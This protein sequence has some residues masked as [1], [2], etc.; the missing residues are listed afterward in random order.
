MT[1]YTENWKNAVAAGSVHYEGEPCPVCGGTKRYTKKR[2]CVAC[3]RVQNS[4]NAKNP[5]QF[6]PPKNPER[7][8]A[9]LSGAKT[10]EGRPCAICGGTT[11]N[12][13]TK[14]CINV[15]Q[16]RVDKAPLKI[17]KY[18]NWRGGNGLETLDEL[19][20]ADFPTLKA[21]RKELSRLRGEYES[22]GM[23][24]CYWSQ[25]PCQGWKK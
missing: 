22:S 24:G 1:Q 16:H 21:Y 15:Y 3:T 23:S 13:K 6:G 9:L 11:R 10:Y 14:Q 17:S 4:K 18:L 25:K 20:L 2:A 7:Q 12:T 8:A 19:H 5:G